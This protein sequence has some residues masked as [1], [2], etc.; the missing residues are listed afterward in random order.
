MA[1]VDPGPDG[2]VFEKVVPELGTFR[3]RPLQSPDDLVVIHRWV[4]HEH[5]RY[6]GLLGKS[7][8]EVVAA[9]QEISRRADVYL[10]FF[11]P[12]PAF[13]LETYWPGRDPV[14]QHYDVQ[15]SDRGLHLLV[16]P[17]EQRLAGFTWAV[18][19]TAMDL[20]FSD[21]TVERIVV[22]P[23][24][25][26]GRIHAL[27]RRAGFRYQRVVE[28]PGKTAHLAF[29]T[30]AHYAQALRPSAAGP[31][32][33]ATL[34]AHLRPEV[35]QE[36]NRALVRKALAELAHE[37]VVE[38]RLERA[39]GAWGHYRL[40]T[41]LPEVE[42]RFRARRLPLD[43]WDI[44]GASLVKRVGGVVVP[45]DAV[46]LV[47]EL[48][49]QLGISERTLPVYLEE[50]LSTL[51]GASYKQ[52]EQRFTAADLVHADYQEI[53]GAMVEGHPAFVANNGRVGFDAGD[54]LAYAPEARAPIQLV[55]L[56]AHRRHTELS[57]VEGLT[58][59]ALMAA[60]LGPAAD[61]FEGELR[62]QGLDP[63]AYLLLP[64]H[65]WQWFNK[66]ALM[67]GPDIASRDLV[68]LGQGADA[69]QAQQSI[70]TLFN[71]S[72]PDRCL[73]KTALSVLNMGFMRGLSADY[74]RATPAINDYLG[75]LLGGDPFFAR[76]GFRLLREVAAI[77]YR[78]PLL[79]MAVPKTS[80]Y[81]KMLAALWRES[82]VPRLAPGQRL[83]TMAALL[84]RDRDGA[85]LA[86]Q[87]IQASGLDTDTWLARYL[88]A[89][90]A[91][92]LHCFYAHDL[93][94]MPH[95]ENIILVLQEQAVAGAFLKDIAEEAVLM[96]PSREPPP[97]ARRLC[98]SVPEPLKSLSI[99]TDVFDGFLR[100]LAQI[101][102]EQGRYPVER[103]WRRVAA[104]VAEYRDSQ[105]E[106][107]P[108]LARYDL[109]VPTFPRSCLNRLQLHDNRQMID[110][111]DP[112]KNLRFAGTLA[113]PI[114]HLD[115]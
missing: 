18:F 115:G 5:A 86:P 70:R 66:L 73:V 1:I 107:A 83:M 78:N 63:R 6:W 110:L 72:R 108:K 87:L 16:A 43:H 8:E 10:G 103:F 2:F 77:G 93:A 62:A 67:F 31:T 57:A 47:L 52:V 99:F 35:W 15:A 28:L 98:A 68:C 101:L 56:A 13:L 3:L 60:E 106:L 23:D 91:P 55:W 58:E 48:R 30:R 59:E 45:L 14:G 21:P 34:C 25:R 112:A 89:Y 26:N 102:D 42:Y 88:D 4:S 27:N 113:N 41:D 105:P 82:P 40:D 97:V 71:T 80:P 100:Y 84:H 19:A 22:E 75:Q 69:Y 81:R 92:L 79:E 96:D 90:L 61:G 114:A 65:P 49:A 109:F 36:V 39:E 54:Y 64:V 12:A 76:K 37:L 9:Y 46:D 38:P 20:L 53:E 95:G 111:A 74:M 17:P 85:A 29:C 94:F 11:G 32:T 51:Y 104:C 7:L 33:D 44:D 24:I 50:I